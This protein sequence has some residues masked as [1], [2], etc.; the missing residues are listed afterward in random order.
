[1]NQ[2][3]PRA[4][5]V[6]AGGS[7]TRLWPLSRSKKP[8]QFQELPGGSL[9]R[10]TVERLARHVPRENIYVSTT[11]AMR[12]AVL[13]SGCGVDSDHLILESAPAG[14]ATA[15]ALALAR[16]QLDHGDVPLLICPSD[17]HFSSEDAVH[18]ALA[19]MFG[20]GTA[21]GSRPVVMGVQAQSPNPRLGYLRVED[22]ES[23]E[24]MDVLEIREKPSVA[25]AAELVSEG[26]WFWNTACYV[27]RPSSA[28]QVYRSSHPAA[29]EAIM[30]ATSARQPY[31]GPTVGGHELMPFF[32]ASNLPRLVQLRRGWSD[33]GTWTTFLAASESPEAKDAQ[34]VDLGE[35]TT[36]FR[37]TGQ[38]VVTIGTR[39]LVIVVHDDAVFVMDRD[40]VMDPDV[41]LEGRNTIVDRGME[42]LL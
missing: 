16:V 17:H 10:L 24:A 11:T 5:V 8:K 14:P 7:G 19:Q 13:D 25:A 21:D 39:N 9:L 40:S 1:M 18:E 27:V 36:V 32:E 34:T 23:F 31:D 12:D 15:F 33:V 41:I 35:T 42:N 26:T 22:A 2:R 30:Q 38:A 29:V 28:M 37:E 20:A 3:I 6:L 4:A